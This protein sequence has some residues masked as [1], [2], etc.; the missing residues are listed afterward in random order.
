MRETKQSPY[1]AN[2]FLYCEDSGTWPAAGENTN[3]LV[4]FASTNS[5]SS[6]K[7]EHAL[8]SRPRSP[9]QSVSG[10]FPQVT[11]LIAVGLLLLA[12]L[13][14]ISQRARDDLLR[15]QQQI[16]SL[17]L[18]T[19]NAADPPASL[20]PALRAAIEDIVKDQIRAHVS[21]SRG[22]RDFA[23]KAAGARVVPELTTSCTNLFSWDCDGPS[24]ALE[25]DVRV[26]KCWNV[27]SLPAQLAIV[28]PE[29]IRPSH[30]TIEHLPI[31]IAPDIGVAPRDLTFWGVVDGKINTAQYEALLDSDSE[32]EATRGCSPVIAKGHLY[33]PLLSFTYD[34]DNDDPVQ[35]FAL[36]KRLRDANISFAVF[37]LEIHGNWGGASTC[38]YRS[39]SVLLGHKRGLGE[40]HHTFVN[41]G[42]SRRITDNHRNAMPLELQEQQTERTYMRDSTSEA[43]AR[44]QLA[45]RVRA[46]DAAAHAE[47]LAMEARL[48]T[49]KPPPIPPSAYSVPLNPRP[50]QAFPNPHAEAPSST[51]YPASPVGMPSS[52][53]HVSNQSY[54]DFSLP[55]QRMEFVEYPSNSYCTSLAASAYTPSPPAAIC[56]DEASGPPFTLDVSYTS[57]TSDIFPVSVPYSNDAPRGHAICSNYESTPPYATRLDDTLAS[58][59]RSDARHAAINDTRTILH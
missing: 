8:P 55:M 51:R 35:T 25:D 7:A 54:A 24:I 48:R 59:S 26:G 17:L 19:P 9:K 43:A 30:V 6:E 23:L 38:L 41:S 49:V 33:A 32:V 47:L 13:L 16:V 44:A 34:I 29:I 21:A 52:S 4:R 36:D 5:I 45:A 20:S 50:Q 27:Q 28:L 46:V 11:L 39:A 2:R 53:Q 31:S 57:N 18:P 56:S 58:L 14:Q 3:K 37:V 22:Q 12:V 10:T 40:G 42:K 1:D 15:Y